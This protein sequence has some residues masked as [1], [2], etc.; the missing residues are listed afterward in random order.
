MLW[1]KKYT[2]SY[3]PIILVWNTKYF[4]Y[5]YLLLQRMMSICTYCAGEHFCSTLE[6]VVSLTKFKGYQSCTIRADVF[7]KWSQKSKNP[8]KLLWNYSKDNAKYSIYIDYSMPTFAVM[9]YQTYLILKPCCLRSVGCTLRESIRSI[10][11]VYNLLT[12]QSIA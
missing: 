4:Q 5:G 2:I 8:L 9:K 7:C 11:R 1:H 6:G 12:L 3:Q 10:R